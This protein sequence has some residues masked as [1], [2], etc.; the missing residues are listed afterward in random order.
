KVPLGPEDFPADAPV[1]R[2]LPEACREALLEQARLLERAEHAFLP[3]LEAVITTADG[4]PGLLTTR[5]PTTLQ[6]RLEG[7]MPLTS[8]LEIV[9]A[10]AE[11]L[12]RAGQV[13]G[14]LRPSNVLL[15]ER[16]EPV[17]A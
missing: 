4:R 16:G 1:P 3:R 15:N 14:D 12:A 10:V 5:Y 17:L 8:A 9:R 2:D 7:G 11:Q 13:H 6:R